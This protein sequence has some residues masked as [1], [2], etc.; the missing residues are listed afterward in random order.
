[1]VSLSLLPLSRGFDVLMLAVVQAVVL[2]ASFALA[3]Q[4]Q[5]CS[6]RVMKCL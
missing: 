5:G 4:G 6:F 3:L 2:L 1:M